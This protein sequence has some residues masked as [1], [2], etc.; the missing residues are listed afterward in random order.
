MIR[1]PELYTL[2][3]ASKGVFTDTRSVL[4]GGM[5]VAIRGETFDGNQYA[6]QALEQG[7]RFSLIDDRDLAHEDGCIYVPNTITALQRLARYHRDHFD[8]PILG[9]TGSN[10]KTT[11]KEL[12]KSVLSQQF[13]IHATK[14]NFNNHLGVPLTL[15]ELNKEADIAVIEMG[16]NHIGEINWLCQIAAPTIGLITNIGSA[17]IEGFGSQEGIGIGKTELYRYLDGHGGQ[18]LVNQDEQSLSS[19][20]HPQ[21]R[22]VIRYG[23]QNL[24]GAIKKATF[25]DMG[26]RLEIEMEGPAED[27]VVVRSHL[28]GDFNRHNI[29]TALAVGGLFDLSLD[30]MAKGIES[31][32]PKNNRSQVLQVGGHTIYLDAYNANPTS[33]QLAVDFFTR[34]A[35][36]NK[37]IVLGDMLELGEWSLSAHTE[38]VHLCLAETSFD[39][40]IFVGPFFSESYREL[41]LT[42]ARVTAVS[43]INEFIGE[44]GLASLPSSHIL[45][46]GS[47]KMQLEGLVNEVRQKMA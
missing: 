43:H 20:V 5:F 23:A 19:W 29:L 17:H 28:Y 36:D 14:G 41:N 11:T 22:G 4:P 10:G 30:Q 47:R 45:L 34:L 18:I 3:Q 26:N 8:I 32:I 46:K 2:Y 37:V 21:L 38:L 12:I 6:L 42:D 15:L 27:H 35:V 31:Y 25:M 16:A 39:R 9:L 40:I 7:A 44:G 1:I 13:E 24:V 33:M